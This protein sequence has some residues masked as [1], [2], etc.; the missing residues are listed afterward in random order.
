M[1]Q[2]AKHFLSLTLYYSMLTIT[3]QGIWDGI[4]KPILVV[5]VSIHPGL[6][7]FLT[8]THIYRMKQ[9]K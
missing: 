4:I 5:S 9:S 3:I 6:D 8:N 2:L 1:R 7:F